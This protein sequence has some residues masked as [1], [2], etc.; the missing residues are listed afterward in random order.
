MRVPVFVFFLFFPG[1]ALGQVAVFDDFDRADGSVGN[2]WTATG[3]VEIVGFDATGD[4]RVTATQTSGVGGLS[5]PFSPGASPVTFTA[6]ITET[7]SS[8]MNGSRFENAFVIFNAGG[9]AYNDGY[10]LFVNR[11]GALFS[12]SHVEL[13]DGGTVASTSL[14]SPWQFDTELHVEVTIHPDGS[15]DGIIT[16]GANT[17]SFCYGPR[18]ISSSGTLMAYAQ[19]NFPSGSSLPASLDDFKASQP[20]CQTDLGFGGPGVMSLSLCGDELILDG[21][22]A[23]FS[24]TGASPSAVV[25]AAVGLFLNPSPFAGGTL[26]PL[27]WATLVPLPTDGNG[28]FLATV[29]GH[30]G[31]AVT[32]YVQIIDPNGVSFDFSNALELE[33]G[34][35]L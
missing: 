14:P 12:N 6:T 26:V 9:S 27:P 3:G 13:L 21:C 33:I 20:V 8:N 32:A 34:T 17:F 25:F 18:A 15:V 23:T 31:P 5:R 2:G 7:D 24:L 28:D 10:G 35:K 29:Q 30:S 11:T 1:A 16:E 19:N 4:G 22:S